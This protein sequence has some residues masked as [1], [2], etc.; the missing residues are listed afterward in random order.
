MPDN[1]AAH[2]RQ[3][4]LC[5]TKVNSRFERSDT[6]TGEP[7][8]VELLDGMTTFNWTAS[9]TNSA[10]PRQQKLRNTSENSEC[11]LSRASKRAAIRDSPVAKA[12]KSNHARNWSGKDASESAGCSTSI[13]I[14]R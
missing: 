4:A 6:N 13:V 7:N 10:G 14:P 9:I 8:Q 2:L 12:A 1:K 5:D 11:M 3:A